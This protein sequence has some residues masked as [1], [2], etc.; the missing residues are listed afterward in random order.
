M[1]FAKIF[2]LVF[3]SLTGVRISTCSLHWVG[4]Q[5]PWVDKDSAGNRINHLRY[6]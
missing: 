6:T 5:K 2:K 3:F 4:A 1:P